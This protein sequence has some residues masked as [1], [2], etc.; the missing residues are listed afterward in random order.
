MDDQDE[1]LLKNFIVSEEKS[2]EEFKK[3]IRR[4]SEFYEEL[5][6]KYDFTNLEKKEL[7]WKARR[8]NQTT[9]MN[10]EIRDKRYYI[11]CSNKKTLF[12]L[13]ILKFL[14]WSFR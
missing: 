10:S 2:K 5:N 6:R 13:I 12:L 14:M 7:F 1:L 9:L 4:L 8:L 3:K 11:P